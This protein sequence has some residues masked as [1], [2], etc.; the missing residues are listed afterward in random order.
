MTDEVRSMETG[1]KQDDL[2]LKT[3]GYYL[4]LLPQVEEV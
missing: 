4:S 3:G 2:Y 1:I